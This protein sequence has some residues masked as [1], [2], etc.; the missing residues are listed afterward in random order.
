VTVKARIFVGIVSFLLIVVII[1]LVRRR[2]LREEFSWLWILAGFTALVVGEWYGLQLFLTRISGAVSSTSI[3]FF[4]CIVFLMALNIH[5]ATK[6]SLL[7]TQVKNL[8][9][10]LSILQHEVKSGR[11][12][13]TEGTG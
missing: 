12:T 1:E 13:K 8:T 4:L 10:E 9:Q 6:I 5:M 3:L 7:M 2:K 11:A